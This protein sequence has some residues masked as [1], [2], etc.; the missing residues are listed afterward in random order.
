MTDKLPAAASGGALVP[1]A[2]SNFL[3]KVRAAK[4]APL[5]VVPKRDRADLIAAAVASARRPRLV[6]AVDATASR[7]PAWEAAKCVMDELFAALPGQID[8]ALAV[9]GGSVMHTF[10]GFVTDPSTLQDRA[11]SVRC[12]SGETRLLAILDRVREEDNVKV[13]VY[14]GDVF[15]ESLDAGLAAADAMRLRGTKLIILHDT[16][17]GGHHSADIFGQLAGRTGGCV[18]PFDGD[19][20]DRLRELLEAVAI[21]AVGGVRLLEAKAKALPAARLLLAH[22][23]GQG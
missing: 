13:V 12:R 6:L 16:A 19:C 8:V 11:A 1:T 4:A 7:E 23:G 14:V 17:T 20:I 3:A 9:H 10:T 22:L 15:E 5:A 18:L 2:K 21:L